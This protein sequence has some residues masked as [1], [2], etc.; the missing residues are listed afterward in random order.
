M[1]LVQSSLSLDGA[2]FERPALMRGAHTFQ[3]PK[4]LLKNSGVRR[5][6]VGPNS[7]NLLPIPISAVGG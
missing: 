2:R 7:A 6:V 3:F 1:V 5:L 4:C